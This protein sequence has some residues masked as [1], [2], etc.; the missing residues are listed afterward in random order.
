MSGWAG[1]PPK[2]PVAKR[3]KHKPRKP[4]RFWRIEGRE[5]LPVVQEAADKGHGVWFN[6]QGKTFTVHLLDRPNIEGEEREPPA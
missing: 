6:L 2:P 5:L 4:G 1:I 3:I